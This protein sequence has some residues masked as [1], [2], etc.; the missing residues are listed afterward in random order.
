M[1]TADTILAG[2]RENTEGCTIIEPDGA[3]WGTVY[4]DNARPVGCNG[5]KF[6]GFL[7]ALERRGLY[8]PEQDDGI[9]GL[10]KLAD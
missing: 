5:H 6:A 10:V 1:I 9:F 8:R 7:S 2:L 4:L 3:R